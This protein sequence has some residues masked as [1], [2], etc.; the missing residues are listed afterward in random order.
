[1]NLYCDEF[2]SV[3]VTKLPL[4]QEIFFYRFSMCEWMGGVEHRVVGYNELYTA[5]SKAIIL[6]AFYT[7]PLEIETI[8]ACWASESCLRACHFTLK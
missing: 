6:L 7:P 3:K 4:K 8:Q 1:M 5:Y 2:S